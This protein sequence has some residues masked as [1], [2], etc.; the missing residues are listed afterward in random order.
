MACVRHARDRTCPPFRR[1]SLSN[2]LFFLL[3]CNTNALDLALVLGS[4][5]DGKDSPFDVGAND[6]TKS[7]ARRAA[8]QQSIIIKV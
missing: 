8:F 7:V 3:L 5:A 4:Q 6:P 1:Y 2:A